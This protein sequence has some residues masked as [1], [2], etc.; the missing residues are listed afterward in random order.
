M[1]VEP[2]VVL[3][4]EEWWKLWKETPIYLKI[5]NSLIDNWILGD[6]GNAGFGSDLTSHSCISTDGKTLPQEKNLRAYFGIELSSFRWATA[7]KFSGTWCMPFVYWGY[8]FSASPGN[9]GLG[10]SDFLRHPSG[11][12]SYKYSSCRST[13]M[14]LGKVPIIRWRR[15]WAANSHQSLLD[16]ILL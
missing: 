8:I 3:W 14:L 1:N 9:C 5:D 4:R 6:D 13:I 16:M 10:I 11:I 7:V 15:A 12:L 2:L